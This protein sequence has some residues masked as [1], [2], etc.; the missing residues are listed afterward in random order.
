MGIDIDALSIFKNIIWRGRIKISCRVR[1]IHQTIPIGIYILIFPCKMK[2]IEFIGNFLSFNLRFSRYPW[3]NHFFVRQILSRY[4]PENKICHSKGKN[5]IHPKI[6]KHIGYCGQATNSESPLPQPHKDL[7]MM[8]KLLSAHTCIIEPFL[9][10]DV[11]FFDRSVRKKPD[12]PKYSRSQ[13]GKNG[14]KES[15]KPPYGHAY[16]KAQQNPFI[17]VKERTLRFVYPFQKGSYSSG[18]IY[19]PFP[20]DDNAKSLKVLLFFAVGPPFSTLVKIGLTNN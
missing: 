10:R 15:K 8:V 9:R 16:Q 4:Y 3:I 19:Y 13:M 2:R 7:R 11:R 5:I 14:W 20:F 1:R 6:H 17:P 12:I 18:H